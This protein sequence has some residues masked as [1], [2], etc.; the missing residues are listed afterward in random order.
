VSPAEL[1]ERARGA[2]VVVSCNP[3]TAGAIEAAGTRPLLV[4]HGVDLDAFRPSPPPGGTPVRLLAVGRLVPKKG[5]DVLLAALSR[6]DAPVRLELVGVGP[7]W[8]SLAEA[9]A[10]LVDQV[11]M[12]GRA[13]HATLPGRYASADV[14]LVPSIVDATGD[15]DGLP[16]VVLEAMA[17]Q[18]PVIASDVAAISTA[19]RDGVTGTLVPPGDPDAL[20]AAI[21][22]LAASARRREAYGAAGRA[23]VAAEFGLRPRTAEFCQVLERAY[24]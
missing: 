20:A 22:G 16:N 23:V 17:S 9:A 15:R 6:V 8:S 4:R 21:T 11:T 5:F 10:A 7:L 14:V 12:T 3:E 24:G 18:R 19:V 1:G 13:T 2:A